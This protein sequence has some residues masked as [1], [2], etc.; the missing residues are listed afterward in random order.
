MKNVKFISLVLAFIIAAVSLFS[1]ISL[2]GNK[3]ETEPTKTELSDLDHIKEKGTLVIGITDY[4]PMNFIDKNGEWAGFDTEFA[5]LVAD[6]LGVEVE[7]VEIDWNAKW[8][9]LQNKKIDCVW[10]GMTLTDEALEKASCTNT[11]IHNAQVVVTKTENAEKY[12]DAESLLD[13]TVAVEAGS[14]GEDIALA[15]NLKYTELEYQSDAINAVVSGAADACIIDITIA[16]AVTGEGAEY[17]SLA[18]T[19]SLSEE[20]YAIACRKG[21]DLTEEINSI[22]AELIADGTLEKIAAKYELTLVADTQ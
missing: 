3:P 12:V 5:Y 11:Y 6:E 18:S 13:V 8:S 2:P 4:A 9:L 20:E 15:A 19:F 21:S 7:F 17:E 10:N 1:C 14:A 16:N 22:M